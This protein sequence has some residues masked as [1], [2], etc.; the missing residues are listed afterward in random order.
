MLA[1]QSGHPASRFV[2]ETA[3][4]IDVRLILP[5]NYILPRLKGS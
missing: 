4:R 3:G 5:I 2:G 1:K